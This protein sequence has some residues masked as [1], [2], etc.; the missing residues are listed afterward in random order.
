MLGER[1]NVVK[2]AA[3]FLSIFGGIC[4]AQPHFLF[5]DIG[6]IEV[7]QE[8][9]SCDWVCVGKFRNIHWGYGIDSHKNGGKRLSY[10]SVTFLIFRFRISQFYCAVAVHEGLDFTAR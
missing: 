10:N 6:S 3:I 1:L 9:L 7:S 8:R 4:I 5:G 2:T